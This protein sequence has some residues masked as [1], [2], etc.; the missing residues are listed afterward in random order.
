MSRRAPILLAAGVT[1][2]AALTA[3]AEAPAGASDYTPQ[4]N[5]SSPANSPT[6]YALN[7]QLTN[8]TTVETGR[9][10]L[11]APPR[12][13]ENLSTT[14]GAEVGSASVRLQLADKNNVYV[15]LTGP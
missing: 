7:T 9:L 3:G 2:L 12:F 13:T 15:N 6:G 8:N 4:L 11:Y 14:V 5:V 1:V 10:L